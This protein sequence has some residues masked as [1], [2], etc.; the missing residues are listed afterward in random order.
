[1]SEESSHHRDQGKEVVDM[2]FDAG[3]F[4]EK[5]TRDSMNALEDYLVLLFQQQADSAKR[6]VEFTH[7]WKHLTDKKGK[8]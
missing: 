4:H 8:T 7:K 6:G 3:L 5:V 2:L 1:M